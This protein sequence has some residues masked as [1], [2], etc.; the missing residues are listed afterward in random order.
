MSNEGVRDTASII[1]DM[2]RAIA[3]IRLDCHFEDDYTVRVSAVGT[4]GFFPETLCEIAQTFSSDPFFLLLNKAYLELS[5][6]KP[7]V[8]R[9]QGKLFNI[10]IELTPLNGVL[11]Q[12]VTHSLS[13]ADPVRAGPVNLSPAGDVLTWTSALQV[14]YWP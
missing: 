5:L 14:G 8:Q 6:I 12:H 1:S 7:V 9:Q 11:V 2:R 3:A 4:G 10:F 13:F